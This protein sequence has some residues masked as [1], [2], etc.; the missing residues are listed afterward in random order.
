[1]AEKRTCDVRHGPVDAAVLEELQ[2]DFDTTE[3]LDAVD[4]IDAIRCRICEP[5]GVRQDLL[6]L[7]GMAMD[8]INGA[9][10]GRGSDSDQPIWELASD[11]SFEL[12]D[13]IEH[14]E[15]VVKS[16]DQLERLAPSEDEWDEEEDESESP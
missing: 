15:S 2:M 7:H 1:M 10:M 3:L 16:L 8:V 5:D 13:F 11:I 6:T 14:L 4:K 9:G 12:G